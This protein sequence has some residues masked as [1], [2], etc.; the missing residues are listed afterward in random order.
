MGPY[1]FC[2]PFSI[3]VSLTTFSPLQKHGEDN[4]ICLLN[5]LPFKNLLEES[6]LAAELMV[7]RMYYFSL[8]KVSLQL[9]C[10]PSNLTSDLTSRSH[11]QTGSVLPDFSLCLCFKTGGQILPHHVEV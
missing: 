8:H 10:Q 3:L 5:I 9:D 4:L 11:L 1:H 7:C 2:V 6:A